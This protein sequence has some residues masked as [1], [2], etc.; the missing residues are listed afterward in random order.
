MD[1]S[2]YTKILKD[3]ITYYLVI[4]A[5]LAPFFLSAEI[6]C[7]RSKKLGRKKKRKAEKEANIGVF[8]FILV[9][10][11]ISYAT[12]PAAIDMVNENYVSV[13]GEYYTSKG[14]LRTDVYVTTDDGEKISLTVPNG[15]GVMKNGNVPSGEHT[16]T[17]WYAEKSKYIL[18]FIPDEAS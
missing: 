13:H 17:I 2:E 6:I 18:E 7:L 9:L 14:R 10:A 3:C 12:I 15:G 5:V 8:G 11:L 16:G 1:F 4:L